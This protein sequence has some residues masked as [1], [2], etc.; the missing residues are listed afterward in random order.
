[1][2]ISLDEHHRCHIVIII[3]VITDT[4]KICTHNSQLSLTYGRKCIKMFLIMKQRKFRHKA[5]QAQNAVL[6]CHAFFPACHNIQDSD[7]EIEKE[8]KSIERNILCVRG[9]NSCRHAQSHSS[10]ILN[11]CRIFI[12]LRTWCIK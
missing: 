12:P 6:Q 4:F 3:V 5:L 11:V 7:E 2:L 10:S 1:M 9:M 8:R